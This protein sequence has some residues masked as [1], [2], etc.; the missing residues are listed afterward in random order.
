MIQY[1]IATNLQIVLARSN[2]FQLLLQSILI[3]EPKTNKLTRTTTKRIVLE[4]GM[5]L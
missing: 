2:Q 3:K 4:K 5:D 1:A